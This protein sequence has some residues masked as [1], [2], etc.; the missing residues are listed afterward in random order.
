VKKA[1]NWVLLGIYLCLGLTTLSGIGQTGQGREAAYAHGKVVSRHADYIDGAIT[2]KIILYPKK[3]RLSTAREVIERDAVLVRYDDAVA[4]VLLCHGFMC[5]KV[6]TGVLRRLFPRGRFNVMSFDFRAHGTRATG[7]QCTFGRDEACD[8]LAAAYFI[9]NDPSLKDKPLFVYGFSMGAVAAIEAQSLDSSL[10]QAM[11][12]DCPFDSAHDV[13]RRVLDSLTFSLFGYKFRMPGRALLQRYA[14]HPYIQSLVKVVLKTV[15]NMDPRDIHI[16]L[17]PISPKDSIKNITIPVFFIV[18]KKDDRAPIAAVRGLYDGAASHY[19]ELW[20][21]NGRGHFDSYF[22]SPE[23]YT[24]KVR[25]FL[26]ESLKDDMVQRVYHHVI[27][28]E[29]DF[30]L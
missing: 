3:T 5:S 18:C 8:V 17:C 29:G 21:T 26:E 12:L 10:F 4:T 22:H 1:G 19:K 13:I 6:D 11:I 27:E 28:D 23:K 16:N 15:A 20:L 24:T 2:D 7:Q 25:Q 30:L 9:K 14:F